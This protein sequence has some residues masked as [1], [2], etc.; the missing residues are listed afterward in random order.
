MQAQAGTGIRRRQRRSREQWR[1]IIQAY[2]AS[3]Q[4]AQSYCDKQGLTLGVFY[5]W[6]RVFKSEMKKELSPFI[7]LPLNFPTMPAPGPAE[8]GWRVE[9]E[10]GEGIVLRLR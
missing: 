8:K 5:K 4:S 9:L 7:E 10:L 2:E 1:E 6:H 3:D